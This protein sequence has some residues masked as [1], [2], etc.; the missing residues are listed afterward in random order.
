MRKVTRYTC[1]PTQDQK[2]AMQ[3]SPTGRWVRYPDWA[4]AAGEASHLRSILNEK[5][6]QLEAA[7]KMRDY[8]AKRSAPAEV[9]VE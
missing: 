6:A 1:N 7:R 5:E 4:A 2:P 9:G 8:Y 3:E